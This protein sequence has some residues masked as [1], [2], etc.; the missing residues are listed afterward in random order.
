M[1]LKLY[2]NDSSSTY[3]CVENLIVSFSRRKKRQLLIVLAWG[4]MLLT[5]QTKSFAHGGEDHGEKQPPA[6][7][8]GANMITRVARVGDLEVV[9]KH[10]PIEPYKE[11]SARLFV[12]YFASNEPVGGAKLF[13]TFTANG[14]TQIEAAAVPAET[15]GMYEAKLPPV[16]K[17]EYK[18]AARVNRN[19]EEQIIDYG[20]LQVASPHAVS[21]DAGASWARTALI[22]LAV[23]V[24]ISLMGAI[25]YRIARATRRGGVKDETTA[26][27]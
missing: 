22:S 15:S 4:V 1:R 23:L 13:V 20:T 17:G 21:D 16:P 12:T 18:V 2:G 5:P 9:L 6:V 3:A 7:S 26:T 11:T 14:G 8:V 27:A 19:G 10:P 25:I 24:S